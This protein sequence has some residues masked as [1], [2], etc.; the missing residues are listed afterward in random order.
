MTTHI[1]ERPIVPVG[2]PYGSNLITLDVIL[3][4]AETQNS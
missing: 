1:T 4:Y 2:H 3:A